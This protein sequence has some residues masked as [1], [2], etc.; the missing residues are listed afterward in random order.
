MQAEAEAVQ[1]MQA[2]EVWEVQEALMEVQVEQAQ[3]Y[4]LQLNMVT[5]VVQEI[6]AKA[7]LQQVKTT[8]SA[9]IMYVQ[10]LA[11]AQM[12]AMS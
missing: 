3:D 7:E 5:V 9:V 6:Q 11:V 2:M 12:V 8:L 1:R 4:H 10:I